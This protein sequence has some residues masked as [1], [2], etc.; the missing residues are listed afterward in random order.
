MG[1]VAA[2][3]DASTGVLALTS[4]GATATVAQWQAALRAI[5][6]TN[7]ASAPNLSNRTVGFVV[8][9]GTLNSAPATKTVVLTA[10]ATSVAS[11]GVP[12]NATYRAGQNLDFV[13][14]FAAPVM[15]NTGGGTPSD[16][17]YV[18]FQAGA[19]VGI[20]P[21]YDAG[22]L[23]N[24]NGLNLASLAVDTPLA[25]NG[26]PV[27]NSAPRTV[28]LAV[29]RPAAGAYT[30]HAAQVLNFL[31]SSPPVLHDLQ[32]GTFTDLSRQPT[33]AF[34]MSAAATA[35]RFELVFG[36]QQVLSTAAG[37]RAAQVFLFQ[38]PAH[39]AVAV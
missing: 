39:V 2:S 19:T 33:Y 5:T 11:V 14:N 7:T 37:G 3:Y 38:N 13:V 23:P 9:D 31:P 21:Q 35:P 28:A 34:I 12:A 8:N 17:A 32:L 36:S 24:T 16:D 25:A 15:A 10:A 29:G 4:S 18:Y 26:L 22:K 6:Y 27:G 1:N 20:D 30:L